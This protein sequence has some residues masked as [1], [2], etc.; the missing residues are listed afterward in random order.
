MAISWFLYTNLQNKT[1]C[2]QLCANLQNKTHYRQVTPLARSQKS[3]HKYIVSNSGWKL[4]PIINKQGGGVGCK[5]NVLGGKNQTIHYGGAGVGRE[6]CIRHSRLGNKFRL[7][8]TLLSFWIKLTQNGCFRTK[9]K[10][11]PPNSIYS[12]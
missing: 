8:M 1:L 6:T 7:K 10:K 12:S 2:W 11:L 5:Q 4:S 3:Q 9:Q